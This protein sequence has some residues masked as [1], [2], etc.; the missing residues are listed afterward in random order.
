MFK[1]ILRSQK[2]L[3]HWGHVSSPSNVPNTGHADLHSML[4]LDMSSLETVSSPNS[5]AMEHP[6]LAYAGDWH[7]ELQG[8]LTSSVE[9]FITLL[10]EGSKGR[11]EG[12]SYFD[13]QLEGTTHDGG[14]GPGG[15]REANARWCSACFPSFPLAETP[16]CEAV[17]PTFTVGLGTSVKPIW[18]HAHGHTQRCASMAVIN[19]VKLTVK[20]NCHSQSVSPEHSSQ[21]PPHRTE[22][23]PT[24]RRTCSTWRHLVDEA[25]RSQ[26]ESSWPVPTLLL[27]L[28]S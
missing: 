19:P 20:T 26:N 5:M 1:R 4:P 21:S 10:K 2:L 14:E 3:G 13:P 23:R 25:G 16:A 15:S 22:R 27:G 28:S 9:C 18:R 24:E 11:K 6:A 17:A 12:R 8:R 7:T